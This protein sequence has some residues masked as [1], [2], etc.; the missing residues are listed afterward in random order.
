MS[1][2]DI[3]ATMAVSD[4]KPKSMSR[5]KQWTDE[6]ENL[7]RFQQAGYRDEFEYKQVKQVELVDRWPET[8]YVKKLQRKDNTFYYY[9]KKRECEDKEVNKV[10]VYAY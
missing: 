2:E 10:K 8:G 3:G 1:E 9:N 7:Y 5:A 4:H 6:I